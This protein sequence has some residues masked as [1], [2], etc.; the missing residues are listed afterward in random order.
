MRQDWV[1]IIALLMVVV[2]PSSIMM[3]DEASGMLS[4]VGNVELNGIGVNQPTAVFPGDR[5]KTTANSVATLTMRGASV[6]VPEDSLVLLAKNEIDIPCGSAMVNTTKGVKARINNVVVA[7]AGDSAKFD[8]VQDHDRMQIIAREGVLAVNDG[9]PRTL[10]PGAVMLT[11]ASGCAAGSLPPEAYLPP[12]GG[13][14]PPTGGQSKA[15]PLLLGLI[16][17]A[18][19]FFL[20][21]ETTKSH[22]LSPSGLCS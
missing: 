21:C 9:S 1:R 10:Q 17:A 6:T 4:V 2:L 13:N 5:V 20:V 12:Q 3:A 19:M 7:P 8:V 16:A 18:G 11:S 14:A 15:G 22:A